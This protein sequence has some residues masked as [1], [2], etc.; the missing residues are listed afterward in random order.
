MEHL[1]QLIS[2]ISLTMGV[3]WASGINL[4][5]AIGTL[6]ILGSTG[7]ITL[8]PDLMI[9]LNPIVIGAAVII[10]AVEFFADKVP[11]LNTGWNSI[12]TFI[13][14]PTGALC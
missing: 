3:A 2:T 4:Y 11:G 5:A 12:H 9:L 6:G 10:Y 7:N 1:N 14:V 8:P 13:R